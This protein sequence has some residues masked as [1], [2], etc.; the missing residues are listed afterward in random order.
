MSVRYT[1]IS[2][3]PIGHR[4]I[5]YTSIGYTSIGYFCQRK[6]GP[7]RAQVVT[8]VNTSSKYRL[9]TADIEHINWLNTADAECTDR[10]MLMPGSDFSNAHTID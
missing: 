6:I 3:T 1:P 5:R 2:Y 9:G 4:P 8:S 10:T 7:M